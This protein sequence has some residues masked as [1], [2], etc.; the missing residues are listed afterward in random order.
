MIQI[1]A[2]TALFGIA[3]TV[4]AGWGSADAAPPDLA[5]GVFGSP[6]QIVEPDRGEVIAYTAHDLQPSDRQ[7]LNV[8]LTGTVPLSGRLWDATTTVA[9]LQGNVIPN[10]ESFWARSADGQSYKIVEQTLTP[11]HIASPLQQGN[12]NT[13]KIYFDVTGAAPVE[14][15]FNDGKHDELVWESA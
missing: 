8:A 2:P 13:F 7:E 9:A 12:Q 4:I 15:V 14:V 3:V 6:Q 5:A 10:L 1:S 11:D